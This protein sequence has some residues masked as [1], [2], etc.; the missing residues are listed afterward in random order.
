MLLFLVLQATHFWLD[1]MY[2]KNPI[3]LPINSSP[4]FLLPKQMFHSTNDQLRFAAKIILF[5]LNYKKKIDSNELPPDTIPSRGGKSTP[6]CMDT[7]HHFFPAYRRPG[8]QKDELIV[9]DQQDDKHAWHVVVACKNQFFSLQVKASDSEDISSEE[10]LVDQLRQI[11]QMA[12]DKENVQLPV[13]LLTTENRQTWAKLR[14]KLLKRNVN[15]V[16]LSI[17]E[18]CLFVV[19]LDEGTR[20]VPSYS[21]I[22]KD[23]TTLELTTM[24]GHVLHGSGTDAGT[25]NRWYDKFLQAIITRDGVVGFVVE[26]SAS[27]GITVLRFCE[28]FLQSLRMFSERKF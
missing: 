19:C 11:I 23:S 14:H 16:S 13:G 5:A 7:Y 26:H 22:R 20:T 17:L 3:P 4:F 6:L 28:E 18:H 8:E 9:S 2:L 1:D 15:S 25:A 12:K 10:T 24:A 27:E 21:T